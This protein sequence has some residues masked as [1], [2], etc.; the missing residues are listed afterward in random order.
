M[1]VTMILV[2]GATGTIGSETVRL[3]AA[4]GE[5]V[6]AMTRDPAA[7]TPQPGVE[8]V[9]G[10]FG[11][12][13]SLARAADKAEAL[14]LLSA[15][16]PRLV[17]HD[18]AMLAA[19]C[20]AGVGKVVKVSAIGTGQNTEAG[21]ADWHLPGERAVQASGLRRTWNACSVVRP[22]RS[23]PGH[24]ITAPRSPESREDGRASGVCRRAGGYARRRRGRGRRAGALT[25]TASGRAAGPDQCAGRVRAG[26]SFVASS[27]LAAFTWAWVRKTLPVRSAPPRS[28]PRRSAPMRSA[29]RRSAP[30][31]SAPMR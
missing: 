21:V 19:A 25:A 15:P 1:V 6:R 29:P 20:A 14:F 23:P 2:T 22:V 5:R 13:G 9:R 24:T 12:P 8:V 28:A 3:L 31:R 30:R 18:E 27:P 10:D 16:G 4:M 11:E 26:G 7:I 17:E